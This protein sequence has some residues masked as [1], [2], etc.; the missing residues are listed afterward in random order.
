MRKTQFPPLNTESTNFFC[1]GYILLQ[2]Y[3]LY[4]YATDISNS[5]LQ[6]KQFSM[7]IVLPNERDGFERVIDTL[8][9]ADLKKM[10][11][12]EATRY[13]KL[14]LPKFKITWKSSL[15]PSL[16]KVSAL[17]SGNW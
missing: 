13:V 11:S 10:M 4:N 7:L 12:N 9:D 14:S 16:E 1:T 6:D 17:I 3:G 8:T 5:Y 15:Q 2:D